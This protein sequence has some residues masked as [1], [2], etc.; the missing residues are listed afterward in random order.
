MSTLST[1]HFQELLSNPDTHA[2]TLHAIILYTYGESALYPD[3]NTG[4]AA[5]PAN[6]LFEMI[7]EDFGVTIPEQLQNKIQALQLAVMSPAFMNDPEMFS[8]ICMGLY[9]GDIADAI[10]GFFSEVTLVELLWGVYEISINRDNPMP[11]SLPIA[12]LLLREFT[13]QG[14]EDDTPLFAELSQEYLALG[15]ELVLLGIDEEQLKQIMPMP[16][17]LR[18]GEQN[19]EFPTHI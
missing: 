5:W 10:D 11:I 2:T 1:A 3:S 15:R 8:S 6:I 17:F 13:Q 19:I 16:F 4:D 9:D 12:N 18:N 7:E 14:V